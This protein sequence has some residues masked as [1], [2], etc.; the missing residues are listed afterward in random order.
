MPTPAGADPLAGRP[1]P[2][3]RRAAGGVGRGF[4]GR[5]RFEAIWLQPLVETVTYN[6]SDLLPAQ[7]RDDYGFVPPAI[8]GLTVSAA[9]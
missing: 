8:R 4:A 6:T 9:A 5:P 7:T 3:A 1:I 2:L